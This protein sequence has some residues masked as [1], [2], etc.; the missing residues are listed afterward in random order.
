MKYVVAE[1]EG[2]CSKDF[3]EVVGIIDLETRP[4]D[5]DNLYIGDKVY[6]VDG[7][8]TFVF[9]ENTL[10]TKYG[11]IKVEDV[12]K[13]AKEEIDEILSSEILV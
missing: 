11:I 2:M 10:E 9:D 8:I 7:E 4:S 6:S 12:T 5:N 3:R 13:Y 1:V